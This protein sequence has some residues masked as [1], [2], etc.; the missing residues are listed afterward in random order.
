[1]LMVFR[2]VFP[3]AL[4]PGAFPRNLGREDVDEIGDEGADVGWR[5]CDGA[6]RPLFGRL[7]PASLGS[8]GVGIPPVLLRVF[9]AGI[10]GKADV[11]G[12]VGRGKAGAGDAIVM[13]AL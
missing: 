3:A 5:D 6:R 8:D 4:T 13:A 10:A 2:S 11:G 1:M 9:A 12:L 7:D